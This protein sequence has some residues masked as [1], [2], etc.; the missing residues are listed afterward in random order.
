M[1]ISEEELRLEEDAEGAEDKASD[2]D[3]DEDE[4][5]WGD[6]DDSKGEDSKD[7][8]EG[9]DTQDDDTEDGKG[10]GR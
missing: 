1:G 7:D 3:V 4:D 8:S 9:D 5:I 6:I 10:S 2:A